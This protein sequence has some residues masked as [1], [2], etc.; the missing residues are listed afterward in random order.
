LHKRG[1]DNMKEENGNIEKIALVAEIVAAYVSNNQMAPSGLPGLIQ[2]VHQSLYNLE[3]NSPSFPTKR[4]EPFVPIKDSIKPDYIV[5]LEDGKRLK[6]LKR[7]LKTAY[8]MTPEQYKERWNLP[9]DYPM[10]APNYAQQRS[11]LAKNSGLG[12]SR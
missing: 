1:K 2:L 11:Q 6:M 12:V 4:G 9:S 10:I 3:F 8:N 7:H 5:C